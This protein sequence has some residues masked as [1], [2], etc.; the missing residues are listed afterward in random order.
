[1]GK[2]LKKKKPNVKPRD[3]GTNHPMEATLLLHCYIWY[4]YTT[5]GT[6]PVAFIR[7]SIHNSRVQIIRQARAEGYTQDSIISLPD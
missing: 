1:M 3:F 7:C 6:L 2:S 5:H 4:L